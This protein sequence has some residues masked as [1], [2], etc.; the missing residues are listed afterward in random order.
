MYVFILEVI[1]RGV[2]LLSRHTKREVKIQSA[3]LQLFIR[4]RL[5][6]YLSILPLAFNQHRHRL[7]LCLRIW[8]KLSVFRRVNPWWFCHMELM[9]SFGDLAHRMGSTNGHPARAAPAS[10]SAAPSQGRSS[11][12]SLEGADPPA[13]TETAPFLLWPRGISRRHTRP[14]SGCSAGEP[15]TGPLLL[16]S[17]EGTCRDCYLCALRCWKWNRL[18]EYSY[19]SL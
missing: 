4:V 3:F 5:V 12:A 2:W 18:A 10:V 14:Q 11:L 16:E 8:S 13:A 17:D 7:I 1:Y 19:S 9:W 6:E 15:V